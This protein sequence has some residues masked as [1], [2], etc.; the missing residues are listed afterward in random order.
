LKHRQNV[1]T[2]VLHRPIEMATESGRSEISKYCQF[3]TQS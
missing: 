3:P 2:H 1:L